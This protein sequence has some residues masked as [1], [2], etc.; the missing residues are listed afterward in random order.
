M[1]IRIRIPKRVPAEYVMMCLVLFF[2]SSYALLEHV[3]VP[4]AVFSVVKLPLL[5]A[6]GICMLAGWRI[7]FPNLRKKRYFYIFCVLFTLCFLLVL[8]AGNNRLTSIG[9]SPYRATFRLVLFLLE[10]FLLMVWVSETGR[11]DKVINFLFWY[12]LVLVLATDF[13]LLSRLIVFRSGRTEY[14]LIGTKFTVS[15]MH[16][17]LVT[18]WFIR[19]NGRTNPSRRSK[20][21]AIL[22][23]GVVVV[24]SVYVD[25]ITGLVGCVALICLFALLNTRFQ[26]KTLKLGSPVWLFL[27]LLASVVFPFIVENILA[28]P[29]VQVFLES[30]LGRNSTLTGRLNIFEVFADKMQEHWLWGYGFGNGNV[31][32]ETLF[33][34]ANTQNAILHW[35]LQV[36]IPAVVVLVLLMLM[37]F[38][39]F[40]KFENQMKIMPLISLIYVYIIMGAVE[41]T[42]SMSFLMWMALVFMY[43]NQKQEA[44]VD[45]KQSVSAETTVGMKN[46]DEE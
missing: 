44:P 15:Y 36:G 41:T 20:L 11:G 2:V 1:K 46:N 16:M 26:K 12:V 18:L 32:A 5:Y 35:T 17:N 19:N 42:F 29:F 38:R 31:T 39:Q 37:I 14:F 33:G 21:L 34:Y 9:E 23:A 22:G 10:L 4:I 43:V 7:V 27:A 8:S 3:S 25:C 30:V 6:G 28:I 13:L 24:V 40:S 45:S